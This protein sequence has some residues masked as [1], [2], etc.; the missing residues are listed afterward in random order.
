MPRVYSIALLSA[1]TFTMV[2]C[3]P[4][5]SAP[6]PKADREATVAMVL[7]GKCGH[8]KGSAEC[9]KDEC[10]ICS[11]CGL[12]SGSTLCCKVAEEFRGQDMCMLCGHVADSDACCK[13]GCEICEKCK[14]H[15]GSPLCCK[16][17]D[18]DDSAAGDTSHGDTLKL[19][20]DTEG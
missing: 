5:S 7:C 1:V 10:I 9:C 4:Q 15:K 20:D 16:L 18:G 13:D 6:A 14:L 19:D 2:G 8:Q 3:E 11:T 17:T 12:H